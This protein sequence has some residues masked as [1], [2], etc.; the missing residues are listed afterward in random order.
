M[1]RRSTHSSHAE[2]PPARPGVERDGFP[3]DTRMPAVATF[4]RRCVTNCLLFAAALVLLFEEW[5]WDRSQAAFARAGRLPL[6][7]RVEPWVRARPRGQALALYVV[8]VAV[9]YPCKMLALLAVGTGYVTAGVAAFVLAKV[10]ATAVFARLYQL[11][12]PAIMQY[13]S[14]RRGR[15]R[16]LRARRFVHH[17]LNLRPFYR[18]AR[19]R[20][21]EQSSRVSRRY[22][23]VY[24]LQNQRRRAASRGAMV[25]DWVAVERR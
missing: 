2:E 16:F 20:V 12:E 17:W 15:D 13:A 8:P 3:P 11:T 14:L 23:A 10:V 7:R 24:R 5:F 4:V 22:R 25:A 1:S 9:I 18:R 21:R 6:L 19:Y